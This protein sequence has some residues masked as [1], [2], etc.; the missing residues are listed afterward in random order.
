MS[1][2]RR[3]WWVS[4][5]TEKRGPY[6]DSLSAYAAARELKLQNPNKHVAVVDPKGISTPIG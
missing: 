1:E 5:H 2:I 4:V 3:D 6:S